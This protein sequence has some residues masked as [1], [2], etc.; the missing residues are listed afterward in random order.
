[1][2]TS[3]LL[4]SMALV[5][6]L[7]APMTS[8]AESRDHHLKVNAGLHLGHTIADQ[9]K[10][11]LDDHK[12]KAKG[13][14]K[15]LKDIIKKMTVYGT[16]TIVNGSDLTIKK[17]NGDLVLVHAANAKFVRRF[18][19]SMTVAD[20]QVNDQLEVFG[21]ITNDKDMSA[22]YIR[23][24]SLQA[25]NGTFS[26]TVTALNT[27]AKTFTLKTGARGEQTIMVASSTKMTKNGNPATFADLALGNQIRVVGIW[28]RPNENVTAKSV[29]ITTPLVRVHVQGKVTVDGDR[30][31]TILGDDQKT[32]TV[33][34]SKANVVYSTYLSMNKKEI[35]MG[36]QLDVWAK[37]EASSTQ[38]K[39]YFVR[40]L[41]Q[42]SKKIQ[43]I[44]M[45]NLNGTVQAQVGDR[46]VLKLGDSYV[47]TGATSTNTIV[48]APVANTSNTFEVKSAGQAELNVNGDPR[49]RLTTPVCAMPSILFH[50]T[51]N[52]VAQAL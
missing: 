22:V 47:W 45:K 33:D 39:A 30:L 40:D 15:E 28:N 46:I 18:G 44:T 10:D 49:C 51:V 32:Y 2:R 9:V 41:S 20:I 29:A 3:S 38:L 24:L 50:V 36:D 1:M 16:V 7:V 52:A 43:V 37:A 27:D 26:G 5:A 25:R 23:D 19:A 4:T 12:E 13:I 34:L 6:T 11:K 17:A 14:S 31:I 35:Q 21:T 48:L 42:I 8:F